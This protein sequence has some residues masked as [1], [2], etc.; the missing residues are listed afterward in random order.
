MQH[1]T[2]TFKFNSRSAYRA[3]FVA[4]RTA[5]ATPVAGTPTV[6]YAIINTK[7]GNAYVGSTKNFYG[8]WGGHLMQLEGGYHS[9][10]MLQNAYNKD[11]KHFIITI[12]DH[13]HGDVDGNI[14]L[15]K[16]ELAALKYNGR[17]YNYKVGNSWVDGKCPLNS[18]GN[19]CGYRPLFK[20]GKNTV[21]RWYDYTSARRAA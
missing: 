11:G 10:D 1:Y 18:T 16:E 12:I 5:G 13:L 21:S 7:D 15:H 9:N 2:G 17:L 4:K 8:R 3:L 6:T 20:R 19:K 14:L